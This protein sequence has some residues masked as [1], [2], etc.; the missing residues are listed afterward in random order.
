MGRTRTNRVG[1]LHQASDLAQGMQ[2]CKK[3]VSSHAYFAQHVSA[4]PFF[5]GCNWSCGQLQHCHPE[6]L[7]LPELSPGA[8]KS[9]LNWCVS[10]SEPCL[11][12]AFM[13]AWIKCFAKLT[14]SR[15]STFSPFLPPP[16]SPMQKHLCWAA[17][18]A[19]VRA[20]QQPHPA[21]S[22]SAIPKPEAPGSPAL[23]L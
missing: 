17:L 16:K 22:S 15:T 11:S 23:A 21:L 8:L 6:L 12:F 20:P 9:L 19:K 7:T 3:A 4:L 10:H 18:S 14:F 13:P 2:P 1:F 5:Q